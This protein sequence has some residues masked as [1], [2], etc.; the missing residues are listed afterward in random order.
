MDRHV[1]LGLIM[2]LV[3]V[4]VFL[5]MEAHVAK[6]F[7]TAGRAA[8]DVNSPKQP[9]TQPAGKPTAGKSNETPKNILK[10][11]LADRGWYSAD[12]NVLR[13]Q[14]EGYFQKADVEPNNDVIAVILPHAGYAYSGQ[15]AAYGL[16]KAAKKYSR[17]VV[18]GPSH[19]APMDNI[20]SVSRATHYQTPLGE[21]PLDVDFIGK[22][23]KHPIFQAV[24]ETDRFEH[25][26]QIEI[27]LLQYRLKDFKLVPIVAGQC[28]PETIKKAADIIRSL[29][30][31]QTLVIASSDFVHYGPNYGYVPF[32]DDV[33][34]QIKS[35][36]MGA[37]ENIAALD[38]KGFTEYLQKTGATVCGSVPIAILL[39]TLGK[40]T[41]AE[42]MK[43]ATSGELTGDFTNS[44]SYLAVAFHGN[45]PKQPAVEPAQT[46]S[47]LT[48]DDKKNLLIMARK[49]ILYLLEKQQSPTETDLGVPVSE[50]MKA[51]RAAFV[52]L[53]K[54]SQLR[55]CIG[56]IFP[57]QPLYKSVI[58]NAINAA[59]NDWRFTPVTIN[60]CNDITIEISALTIPQPI[61]SWNKIRIGTDGVV[62]KKQ[63][64]SAVFLPQVA[65]E[66]GWD[67]NQMLTQLSLK[68]GLP[69]DAWKQDAEFLVFQAEVF[70]EKE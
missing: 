56:D 17:V 55:G 69:G 4:V 59:V 35:I 54:H 60:E 38:G 18:I 67:V 16:K 58:S 34:A 7:P 26:V 13:G 2:I 24:P 1:K 48:A 30:D 46:S 12:A 11:P 50:S 43:Y 9:A 33:P 68:A 39:S 20:L 31:G 37:Y 63:G 49:T 21:I 28:S 36:D 8:G 53:R 40:D 3:V 10:S 41:K 6:K 19:Q 42:L 62:L 22:L 25:S 44:V 47:E 32:K 14:I 15:T 5:V 66:Q 65:P 70:G 27:P 52:T 29:V 57:R 23:L 51:P 64:R 45:W 61:D